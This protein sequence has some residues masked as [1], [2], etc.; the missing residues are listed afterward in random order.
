M[1]LPHA[2]GDRA[3]NGQG[4]HQQVQNTAVQSA[5]GLFTQLLGGAGTDGALRQD[6]AGK[7]RKG[8]Q[9]EYYEEDLLHVYAGQR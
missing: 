5:G 7:G 1:V 8:Y 6:V 2:V 4:D 3:D 9:Q